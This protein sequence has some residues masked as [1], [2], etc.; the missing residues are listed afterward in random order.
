MS[1]FLVKFSCL[2]RGDLVAASLIQTAGAGP[3]ATAMDEVLGK[4]PPK[5]GKK[6]AAAVA[7]AEKGTAK[8]GKKQQ[9]ADAGAEEEEDEESERRGFE[10]D[11]DYGTG[12]AAYDAA[13]GEGSGHRVQQLPKTCHIQDAMRT[14]VAEFFARM[15]ATKDDAC[16]PKFMA[17]D[18]VEAHI[19]ALCKKE[20][21]ALHHI[22]GGADLAALASGSSS[23]SSSAL[24]KAARDQSGR[25]YKAFFLR[26]LAVTPNSVMGD[27]KYEHTQNVTMQRILQACLV[28]QSV[29]EDMQQQ[30]D[31]DASEAGV[32]GL[33]PAQIAA[34][35]ARR[36]AEAQQR[37][38][39]G[40]LRLQNEV[41]ALIDSTTADNTDQAGVRQQLEKKEGLF[42]KNMMGKR[43]NYAARSVI[44]P[45]P[46]IGAGE[47]GV[48]PYFAVRLSFPEAVTPWN[49]EEMRQLVINGADKHPGAL[50]VED[51]RGVVVSL[52]KLDQKR[53]EGIAKQLL[54]PSFAAGGVRSGGGGPPGGRGQRQDR[55]PPSAGRGPHVN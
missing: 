35:K 18:E 1:K 47:I 17:P 22:Y 40:W 12:L 10:F 25:L 39:S 21:G 46:Y 28:L 5:K 44:S 24:Y 43:V 7:A 31:L 54:N 16:K 19:A 23:S 37:F 20:S 36:R 33:T 9:L 30:Q 53:R 8:K 48:P 13:Y 49:V 50:A 27:T 34:I 15:P 42:R 41:N 38:M 4:T 29:H 45:D 14:A 32:G 51:C 26:A 6:A 11:G 3:K 55:P 52:S 2:S